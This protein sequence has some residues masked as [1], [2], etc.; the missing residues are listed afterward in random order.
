[1]STPEIIIVEDL[2]GLSRKAADLFVEQAV[3]VLKTSPFFSMALSG[4]STPESLYS[5]FT[6][7]PGIKDKIAWKRVHIF[8]GDERHVPSDHPQSNFRMANRTMLTE[9]PLP[10]QNIHRVMAE[11]ADADRVTRRYE[12]EISRFFQLQAGQ[13]PRFDLIWLGL[14]PDGHTASLFPHSAALT[15]KKRLVA[16]NWVEQF[17]SH[18]ITMTL[19]VLNH[20]KCLIF[21]VSGAAK[22][23]TLKQVLENDRRAPQFPAQLIQPHDGKLYWI[24]DRAAASELPEK[25]THRRGAEN[26]QSPHPQL[27]GESI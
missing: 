17:Q 9:L 14:G 13:F 20:A 1:L 6:S 16:A 25:Y 21:L 24:I 10:P 18:R 4:G 15:E 2:K 8:W 22:A 12:Q 27:K 11:D 3:A 7:D 5:L 19:P 26:T 23:E